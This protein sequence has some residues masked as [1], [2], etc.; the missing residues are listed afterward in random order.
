MKS[1]IKYLTFALQF[2]IAIIFLQTLYFKFTAHPESVMIFS[3]L[4]VEPIGRWATG[5]VELCVSILIVLPR[6]K[7][8]GAVL[9]ALISLGAIAAHLGPIGIE[10]NGDGGQLFAMAL[11][12][13]IASA[14]ILILNT[15][16]AKVQFKSLRK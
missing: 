3:S 13:F 12:I 7:F 8:L 16:S 15:E 1:F 11:G 5:T 2:S 9:S 6:T 4:G 10:S 14:L